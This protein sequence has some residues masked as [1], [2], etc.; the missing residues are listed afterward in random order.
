M[1]LTAQKKQ[2]LEAKLQQFVG[3]SI[4]VP[5]VGRDLVNE[6]MIRQWCD[7]MGDTNP[8]YLDPQ[9][10]GKTV[11]GGIVAPPTM[12]QAWTMHGFEMAQ[13]YDEPQD[14]QQS[15]HKL[16]ADYGYG[17]VV[18][19]D[20]R[21][22]YTRYLRLGDQVKS[23]TVIESISEEKAT[24]L[25][26]GYFIT[27]R[28]TF[29]DQNDEEVGWMTF[30]VLKYW[31][32]EQAPAAAKSDDGAAPAPPGRIRPPHGYD[33]AWWWNLVNEGK[34]PIQKCNGCGQL[35]H[36][37]RP[38]CQKCRSMDLG[39]VEASGN[40]SVYSFTII[41]HPQFPGYDFP[42]VAA[43]VQL[44]EGTRIVSNVVDCN[45]EDVEVGMP[46]RGFIHTDDDG[47]MLP[48]FRPAT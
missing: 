34:F 15:L 12:L 38:M 29:T 3:K 6:P 16:L 19:T 32:A 42:I 2:E 36:P 43:L 23:D 45:P 46:V 27:T 5:D 26:L 20:T 22:G 10:A 7:A 14:L 35:Y 47:F 13:G 17:G 30:R 25:G 18:G 8:A 41:H 24:H 31:P 28:T 40:G 9:A 11:H 21:Q 1:P 39:W 4:G 37:P 48:L 44:E 33:N